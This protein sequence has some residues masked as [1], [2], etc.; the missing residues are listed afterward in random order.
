MKLLA[1]VIALQTGCVLLVDDEPG[2]ACGDGFVD[3]GEA[4]DDGN[5]ISDDGC[6]SCSIDVQTR[7][8]RVNWRLRDIATAT[9][10]ACPASFDTAELVTEQVT[11]SGEPIGGMTVDVHSCATGGGTVPIQVG[12]LGG[13]VRTWVRI[14]N[15]AGNLYA[16]SL[17]TTVD[18][19][20]A[21]AMIDVG[22]L[23]DGG[24]FEVAWTLR[25]ATSGTVLSCS[26][27]D[28]PDSIELV[29]TLA[30]PSLAFS[31]KFTCEDGSGITGGL[32][33]GSYTASL[34]AV[35]NDASIGTA[36]ALT[37]KLILDRNRVTDLG[38]VEIPIQGL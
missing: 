32:R 22:I 30:S 29:T 34:A 9:V 14:T 36:P 18:L 35:K 37:N 23:N 31:D 6:S 16:E 20:T 11:V 21:D 2:P 24:Y 5:S 33:A 13:N 7:Y 12:Q 4:C 3:S 38:T 8:L 17:V 19:S 25:G 10:T 15:G 1:V 28:E 26:S 27:A